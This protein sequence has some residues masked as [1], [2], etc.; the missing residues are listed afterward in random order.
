MVSL[1]TGTLR[2]RQALK[3][4]LDVAY[5][6]GRQKIDFYYPPERQPA[7]KELVFAFIHGGYWQELR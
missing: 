4:E 6:A 7:E 1:V 2:A 5:G 3:C